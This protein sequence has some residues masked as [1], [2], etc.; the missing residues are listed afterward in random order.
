MTREMG[1]SA[2]DSTTMVS[3]KANT[4][5]LKTGIRRSMLLGTGVFILLSAASVLSAADYTAI[6]SRTTIDPELP[7]IEV[8]EYLMAR[9][10]PMPESQTAADWQKYADRVRQETLDNVVFKGAAAEWRKIPTKVEWLETINGGPGYKIRKLRYEAVPGLWI[11]ALLY[12]PDKLEARVPVVMNVNG[13]DPKGKSVPYKQLRCIN[14]AKRGMYALNVEWLNMGQLKGANY[15]HYKMNQLDLCGTCG[16]APFYL[17][18]SRGLDVLL[19][20][21]NADPTRV[22]VAGLSGGGWQT[23]FISSLDT[24]VTLCNPVAGYSSLRTRIKH[25]SSLG[26]SEQNPVDLSV[27][28]DY[29]QMT[30]MLAPRPALLTYNA[31]DNCCFKANHALPLLVEAA[32]PVYAL[33]GK[34]QNLRSHVNHDPGDHNFGLDNRQQLYRMF[35]DFFYTDKPDF[36]VTEIN[37]GDEIKT[38][39]ELY[40]TVPEKNADFNSLARGLMTSLP[41]DSKL[42]TDKQAAADW[43]VKRRGRLAEVVRAK[44]QDL[45]A[46]I[47]GEQEFPGGRATDWWLRVGGVWTVPATELTPANPKGTVVM[48]ADAGRKSLGD[49]VKPLVE[50]GMRV[51]AIDPFYLGESKIAQRDYLFAI[52]VSSVGERPLGVQAVQLAAISRW[53][54]HQ[55]GGQPV[56][57]RAVGPRTSLMA[58]VA[59]GLETEAIGKL[60]LK[61]SL[62][63]LKEVI[64]QN[65][66]MEHVPD[67]FCFGLLEQFDIPQL[68]A[69]SAPRPVRFV[70]PSD[71]AKQELSG[72]KGL[73]GLFGVECDPLK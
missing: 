16:L 59:A 41:R 62:G 42:P 46:A 17:S 5:M 31:A 1:R 25:L 4:I 44:E 69:L 40:V 28:T 15:D 35:K 12:V 54:R 63:S 52:A 33:Y 29:A 14:Q 24:R 27:Y 47:A 51:I 55:F 9:V 70:E 61:G 6:L 20:L 71:R 58:L 72:L 49:A 18:M 45:Q 68:A 38:A 36:D 26:D 66:T 50:S 30:A 19:G 57:L 21:E 64:E 10:P 2:D 39:E 3:I 48:L 73:Y 60:E 53:A 43:Q 8:Q 23:I 11:P 37:S 56:E 32:R 34:E 22:A 65:L 7:Q 67:Y 13:H